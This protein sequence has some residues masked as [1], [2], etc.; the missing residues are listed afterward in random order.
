MGNR[1]KSTEELSSRG[2]GIEFG[3]ASA[4]IGTA[5]MPLLDELIQ[6]AADCPDSDIEITG[7]TDNTGGDATNLA[8]SQQRANAVASYLA[9]GGIAEQR[10]RAAGVGSAEPLVAEDAPQARRL[11]RRIEIELS[12]R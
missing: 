5:S 10:I 2:R 4:E 6:I 7:H 3:R 9:A 11:N 8:L 12:F 1:G